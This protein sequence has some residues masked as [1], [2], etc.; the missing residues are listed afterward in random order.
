VLWAG[1]CYLLLMI[2]QAIGRYLWRV[3][4]IGTSHLIARSL[5][6]QLYDHLQHLPLGYY[7]KVRTGDLMSRATNDIES[8]RMAVGPGILVALD[9]LFIFI[10]ILPAMFWLSPKLTL[11][12]FVFYPLVPWI[13]ARLGDKIDLL[14]E[15]MQTKM[16]QLSAFTQE[17]FAAVRLIKSL[18]L[19][20]R[21]QER[22]TRLSHEY[23][24]EGIAAS[25][26]QAAFSPLLGLL[27]N[28][29]IFL[30]LLA[31]GYDVIRGAI[32]LGTFVAL[33]R[34]VVQLSWPMEA[35]GWAVTMNKEGV[36]ANR[37]L[38]EVMQAS[39]VQSVRTKAKRST[40]SSIDKLMEIR[41][42]GHRFSNAET[43]SGF[44]LSL[45]HLGLN[46]GQKIGLVGSVG[47]GKTTLFNLILRLYE[48]PEGTIFWKGVDVTA[49][50]L[51]TLRSEIASVEQQIF[52]FSEDITANIEM[53]SRVRLSQSDIEK[54]AQ[55]ACIY[56]EIQELPNGFGTRL[57]E[58]GVNL[59]GGQKQRLALTRALV[60][61]PSLLLLDDSFS[62]VDVA[63]EERIINHLFENYS[64]MAFCFAS[65]R[66]SVM[67]RMDEIWLVEGGGLLKRGT[68]SQLLESDSLYQALWEK[69]ERRTEAERFELEVEEERIS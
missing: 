18:V 65:H 10:M 1:G 47:S 32:T 63:V 54:V 22:F 42:L 68:H 19:E 17:S 15:R 43:T 16:S 69:S 51:Q 49:I 34:F 36:S 57:G 46:P 6:L 66:L 29:G 58:R 61:Q 45:P 64:N 25:K 21:V 55:H 44:A 13:T 3:Y 30:I 39:V 14:F 28:L 31:G 11:I 12:S 53:G 4:L 38:C 67:P 27:T 33:Q 5:R 20:N 41:G 50:E 7:Q 52:L 23:E 35:I 26:Y 8:I 48:P 37:R 56:E 59:S 2:V 60:R 24:R 62:A 9:A 40:G